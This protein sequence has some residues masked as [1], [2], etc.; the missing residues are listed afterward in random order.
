MNGSKTEGFEAGI[1][2]YR[3]EK[4]GRK[5]EEGR[6]AVRGSEREGWRK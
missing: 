6:G 1:Q 3:E 5:E 2:Y 4:Q